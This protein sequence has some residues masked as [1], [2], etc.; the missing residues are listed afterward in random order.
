M[1]ASLEIKQRFFKLH[2]LINLH[3]Y[4]YY[5]VND[6]EIT[7]IEYDRLFKEM[8]I[9]EAENPELLTRS[10]PIQ[11]VGCALPNKFRQVVHAL[12]MLSLTN[13]FND[14]ELR[15]FERRVCA[16]LNTADIQVFTVEPKLDGL[17]IS[18]R[19]ERG[20]LVQAS[21]RGNGVIGE[22]VT[23]NVRTI[24]TVPLQLS[25]NNIPEI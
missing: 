18:I 13:A 21:T 9:L 5:I 14:E 12:P 6:P 22:D 15:A 8:Q 16:L 1:S 24:K 10:S 17:A 20:I 2:K 23:A 7:D 4:Q 11:K 19:Y 3:N 25:G